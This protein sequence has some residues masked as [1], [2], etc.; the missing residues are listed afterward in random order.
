MA[1]IALFSLLIIGLVHFAPIII[2]KFT[3]VDE[4]LPRDIERQ[5]RELQDTRGRQPGQPDIA[6][7]QAK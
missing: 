7:P 1:F 3:I 5:Y 2:E 6:T 4:Y